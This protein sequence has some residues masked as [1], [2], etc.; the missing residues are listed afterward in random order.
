M[1][2]T[3]LVIAGNYDEFF[4]VYGRNPRYRYIPENMPERLCG[5][6]DCKIYFMGTCWRRKDLEK[7][8]EECYLRNIKVIRRHYV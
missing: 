7:I 5:F 4:D 6:R 3:I 1:K 8:R 2:D